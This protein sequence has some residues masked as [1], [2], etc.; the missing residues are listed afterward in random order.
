MEVNPHKA[1]ARASTWRARVG[2]D[3]SADLM[4]IRMA[5]SGGTGVPAARAS[6]N[7]CGNLIVVVT[8]VASTQVVMYLHA[9][10]EH[11]RP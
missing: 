7:C 5:R 11:I 2:L 3:M 1:A 10:R 9:R 4:M 6:R 8:S